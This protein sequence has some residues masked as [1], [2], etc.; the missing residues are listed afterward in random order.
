MLRAM[1]NGPRSKPI[2]KETRVVEAKAT[3]EGPAKNRPIL[4][5][6][7]GTDVGR[8]YPLAGREETTIGRVD[9]C[10]V[11]LDD[12]SLSRDHARILV[13]GATVL[14][15]DRGSTNGTFVNDERLTKVRTLVDNDRLSFG[16][17]NTV[18]RFALAT[19]EE[20][21]QLKAV[22]ESTQED[23]L[24]GLKNRRHLEKLLDVEIGRAV[25]S[26]GDLAIAMIDLDHFKRVND[27]HGHPAGDAV[28]RE[29]A[30]RIESSL[31]PGDVAARY[32][33]EEITLVLRGVGPAE[34]AKMTEA[35]RE[36][37]AVA[38]VALGQ[39]VLLSV[40]ASCGVACVSECTPQD[41]ATLLG[42]ADARLY[43]AKQGGR[44]RVVSGD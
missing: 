36:V 20:E 12:D 42:R 3:S 24:T 5:V 38:P 18:L 26:N 33:G 35:I 4:T 32:G 11:W 30:R 34:A 7:T 10:D 27:E 14:L 22:W 2:Y 23:G 31:R 16:E 6:T 25:E 17:R 15:Q 44:N 40:T 21:A 1:A 37:I 43:A 19:E 39:G 9:L 13:I 28:L 8:V 29:T 41:K